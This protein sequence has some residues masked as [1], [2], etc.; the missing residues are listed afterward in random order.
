MASKMIKKLIPVAIVTAV[1]VTIYVIVANPPQTRRSGPPATTN[2]NVQVQLLKAKPFVAH[3]SSFGTV[4]PR[5]QTMLSAQVSGQVMVINDDFREGGFFNKGDVLVQLDDRDHRAEVQQSQA[6]LMNA[7]QALLEEQARVEQAKTDWQRLGNGE[8][9]NDLVLRKPQLAAAQAAVLSAQ[10]QLDK[11]NLDLERTKIKAPF[12]GRVL[13]QL[14]D[15]GEVVSANTELGEVYASDVVEVRLPIKNSD[16]DLIKLPVRFV[17]QEQQVGAKVR[18]HS[19]VFGEQSFD[20]RLVRTEGAIDSNAQQLYVVGQIS[21]PFAANSTQMPIKIGQ[22]IKADIEAEPLT[23]PIVIPNSAIYQGS[24]VYTVV[25]GNLLRKDISVKWQDTEQSVIKSGLNEGEL[26]VLTPLG[27]V[28]SGTPVSILNS[29]QPSVTTP[30]LAPR[31]DKA[32]PAQ[33]KKR[34]HKQGGDA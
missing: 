26:L 24:Y 25:D 27:Q 12:A 21:D 34:S 23:N 14:V 13:Q 7:K 4:K 5:V 10:A 11:A 9:A 20:G 33:Q 28:S 19:T 8:Q 32:K 31:G 6:N 15:V 1:A 30:K 18:F 16:L 2:I 3:V 22:Y 17:G 29:Q